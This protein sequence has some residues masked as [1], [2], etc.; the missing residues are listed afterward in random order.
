VTPKPWRTK[1]TYAN[2]STGSTWHYTTHA[3]ALAEAQLL[4]APRVAG[5]WRVKARIWKAT[6]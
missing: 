2:G 4:M 3:D 5:N 6:K 1:Y